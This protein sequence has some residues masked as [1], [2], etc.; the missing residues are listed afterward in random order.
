MPDEYRSGVSIEIS[1]CSSLIAVILNLGT[2]CLSNSTCV[3]THYLRDIS[4]DVPRHLTD[5]FYDY[6]PITALNQ[7]SPCVSGASK[8]HKQICD[9]VP[10]SSRVTDSY[11][12]PGLPSKQEQSR[13][14]KEFNFLFKDNKISLEPSCKT[15]TR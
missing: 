3:H 2:R 14:L 8:L 7:Q 5:G 6:L 11:W 10:M 15:Q 9:V 12:K 13:H 1:L 4:E